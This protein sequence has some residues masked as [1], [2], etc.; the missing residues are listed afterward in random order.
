[1]RVAIDGLHL[2]GDYAGVKYALANLV[3]ALR[4]VQ[5]G[6]EVVLYVPRD[7]KGPPDANGDAGLTIRK[8]WFP[9]RWRA[10]RALWRNFRLQRRAYVDR[11]DLIH[12]P[13]YALPSLLAKPA[14]VTIHD[15]IALSHPLFCTPG[16]A[17]VQKRTIARS[18]KVARRIIVPSLAARVDLLRNVRGIRED[19]IDVIPWGVGPEFKPVDADK[20]EALR[21]AMKLPREYV[22]FVG[23]LE[24][25]KNIP[26]L[27]R[28]F[29]AAKLHRKLPHKLV[30][31]GQKG[32]G[33]DNL[34]KLIRELNA[35]DYVYFTGYLPHA[36]LPALY[37]L[38]DLFIMP[39]LIEGFGMPVLEAMACGCPVLISTDPALQ[40]VSASAART[41]PYD[42]DK[43]LLPLREALEDLLADRPG[44]RQEL[45]RRGLERARLFSWEK[46]AQ[47]T[48][49]CYARALE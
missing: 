34:E 31:A 11:C 9:G 17:K 35:Q 45:I 28:G 4:R 27:I 47:L 14:V 43:P 2:F 24:P 33:L 12:G 42:A 49:Q 39:S 26:M 8:T 25:K 40:E 48:R 18:V 6:D 19:N 38:A 37:S 29:F 41:I 22:L 23:N 46:T 7:F 10:I 30:I 21:E 5:P 16:S 3:T 36:A 13:V 32:W 44:Q 1:M 20:R 15:V